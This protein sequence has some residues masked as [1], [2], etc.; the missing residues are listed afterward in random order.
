M[1]SSSLTQFIKKAHEHYDEQKWKY[2]KLINSDDAKIEGDE[3]IIYDKN[4]KPHEHSY[5]ILGYYDNQTNIWIWGWLLTDL[6]SEHTMLCK[7][8]LNYGLKLEPQTNTIE[9]F[10]IKSLLVNSRIIVEY[11]V[12]LDTNLAIFSYLIHYKILFIYPRKEFIDNLKTKF[13]TF[14]YIIK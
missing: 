8:I 12:Q 7:E 11:D 6:K 13:V 4:N 14:Y 1:D 2:N 5:E 9:H 3:I 10:F